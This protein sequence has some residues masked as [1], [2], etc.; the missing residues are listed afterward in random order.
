MNAA[1]IVTLLLGLLDRAS[2]VGAMLGV[3]QAENRNPTAAEWDQVLAADTAARLLLVDAIA[4][5]KA[6]ASGAPA[7]P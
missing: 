7:T 4:K 1:A 3:I 2:A 6:E 5:A